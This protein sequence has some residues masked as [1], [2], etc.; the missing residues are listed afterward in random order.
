MGY[1]IPDL[2]EDIIDDI[3][4]LLHTYR[5][6]NIGMIREETGSCT[7]LPSDVCVDAT[8]LVDAVSEI[9]DEHFKKIEQ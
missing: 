3:Y 6:K 8:G 9:V 4:D 5:F 7:Y 1:K 2:K